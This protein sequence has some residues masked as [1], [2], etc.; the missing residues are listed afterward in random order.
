L[1][2]LLNTIQNNSKFD[3]KNISNSFNNDLIDLL[4]AFDMFDKSDTNG[5]IP[6][7]DSYS[8]F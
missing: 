2:K 7:K 4:V 3:S 1:Q 8:L 5:N 6:N